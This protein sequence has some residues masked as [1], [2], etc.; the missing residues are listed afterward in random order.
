MFR[1]FAMSVPK[2]WYGVNVSDVHPP[3][4]YLIGKLAWW[5]FDS[6]RWMTVLPL[7]IWL[8]AVAVF[9]ARVGPLL[10]SSWSRVLFATIAFFHPHAM[11]WT[12]TFRWYPIWS[13]LVLLTLAYGPLR[14]PAK[15]P[16]DW[17][18]FGTTLALGALGALMFYVSYLTVLWLPCFALAWFVRFGRSRMA[19]T[20]LALVLVIVFL[21]ATP[22]LVPFVQVHLRGAASQRGPILY[23]AARLLHG[24]SVGEAVQP[25]HPMGLLV[26]PVL[27]AAF[28]LAVRRWGRTPGDV[29]NSTVPQDDRRR[30]IAALGTWIAALTLAGIATGLAARPRSFVVLVVPISLLLVTG[31]ETIRKPR[32]RLLV[33]VFIAGWLIIGASH[34]LLRRA[35]AKAGMN[36]HPDELAARIIELAQG[37]PALVFT[38][39]KMLLFELNRQRQSRKVPLVVCSCDADFVHRLPPAPALSHAPQMIFVVNTFIGSLTEDAARIT[40]V[41][42]QARALIAADQRWEQQLGADPD[43]PI[44]RWLTGVDLPRYR[45]GVTW[46]S[47]RR[48]E[49]TKL[50]A[51]A[52]KLCRELAHISH[53]PDWWRP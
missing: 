5:L 37:R 21:G 52:K 43:A 16:A 7:L 25:W 41:F 15:T 14:P 13:G 51:R 31:L 24:L 40:R 42:D 53:Y 33:T 8:G 27:G 6:P 3:G 50:V 34:L 49:E 2:L 35:T 45:Y 38:Y 18:G 26:L 19:L 22:Q 23:G 4:T 47:P 44:K 39:D 9:V 17:P 12:N 28:I 1:W 11:M 20:G 36:D 30:L 48:G 46:G 29:G 32:L 10:G